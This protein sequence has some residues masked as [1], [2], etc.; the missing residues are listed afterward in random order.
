[1]IGTMTIV[2]MPFILHLDLEVSIF[3]YSFHYL[4]FLRS[5]FLVYCKRD[6]D[7]FIT[8]VSCHA[9]KAT[10]MFVFKVDI[11]NVRIKENSRNCVITFDVVI[12]RMF[13]K[14]PLQI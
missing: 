9:S 2:S 14:N 4:K 1:M 8:G 13:L 11:K 3:F 5:S 7:I 6:C 12:S 10:F